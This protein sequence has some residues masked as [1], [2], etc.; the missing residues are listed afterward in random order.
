MGWYGGHG[1]KYGCMG[2]R[3]GVGTHIAQVVRDTLDATNPE[4]GRMPGSTTNLT[5]Y[6]NTKVEW[7]DV[8]WE[9]LVGMLGSDG[10][11][12]RYGGRDCEQVWGSCGGEG[13]HK[14][15]GHCGGPWGTPVHG[16][17]VWA[18]AC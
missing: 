9:D 1:A 7:G 18:R 4:T 2:F 16:R 13:E 5:D 12:A 15:G 14:G 6:A 8:E 17:R 10:R 3:R 11:K